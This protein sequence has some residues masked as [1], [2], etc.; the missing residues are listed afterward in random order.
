MI[1]LDH[2]GNDKSF[3]SSIPQIL[4]SLALLKLS[5]V[6]EEVTATTHTTTLQPVEK[7]ATKVTTKDVTKDVTKDTTTVS[8]KE[9]TLPPGWGA[10]VVAGIST[11]VDVVSRTVEK[12]TELANKAI[13]MVSMLSW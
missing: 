13:V 1:W 10:T 3:I 2:S 4:T 9:D 6:E 12:G 7:V 11:G 5:D 8:R